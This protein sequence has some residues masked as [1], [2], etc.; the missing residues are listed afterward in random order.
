MSRAGA[1]H[2]TS[3]DERDEAAANVAAGDIAALD[4]AVVTATKL[5]CY[6]LCYGG[7]IRAKINADMVEV[8]GESGETFEFVAFDMTQ[9]AF[10]RWLFAC[11]KLRK[12]KHSNDRGLD[13]IGIQQLKDLRNKETAKQQAGVYGRQSTPSS[14]KMRQLKIRGE[15][16][17]VKIIELT[18]DGSIVRV[19]PRSGR[20]NEV[21]HVCSE[22]LTQ[23]IAFIK[24]QGLS[25][26]AEELPPNIRKRKSVVGDDYYQIRS[27]SSPRKYAY[28]RY[29]SLADAIQASQQ[30]V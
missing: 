12:Q 21:L 20:G 1:Q 14:L 16:A 7:T 23:C 6:E 4:N 30:Q 2:A 19:L 28:T 27:K 25:L 3:G 18:V 9:A 8:V 26:D 11:T 13:I 29:E 22:D 10:A 24:K 5:P 17:S 15:L